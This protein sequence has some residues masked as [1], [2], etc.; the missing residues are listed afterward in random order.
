MK[1]DPINSP[2]HYCAGELEVIDVIEKMR[3]TDFREANI[4]KYIFRY[5]YKNGVEDLKKARYYLDRLISHVETVGIMV[6]PGALKIIAG[7]DEK[8]MIDFFF[9]KEGTGEG[10]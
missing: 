8:E 6:D 1:N 7:M 10:E 4:L 9:S 5:K 3:M 2:A